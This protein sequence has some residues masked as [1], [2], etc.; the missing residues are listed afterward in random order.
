MR[1]AHQLAVSALALLGFSCADQAPSEGVANSRQAI[2]DGEASGAEQDGVVLLRAFTDDD[3]ELVC[4]GS[5]V[6]PNL[7]LTARHCVSYLNEA[8]FSCTVRGE[9][10]NNPDGGGR[11]GLH[12][13]AERIEVYGRKLPRKAPLARGARVISTLSPDICKNDIAFVVL[14]Q[15]VDLPL[16]PMRI[17]S[18]ARLHETGVLVGFGLD[19]TQTGIDYATQPRFQKRD[20]DIVALGPDSLAD[21]VT[22]VPPRAL[23]LKGPSGCIGDSGGP[24]LAQQSGAVLGVYSLQEGESCVASNVKHQMVHVP[25]FTTLIDEAFE[26]AG[27]LPTPEPEGA[28]GAGGAGAE[29]GAAGAAVEAA[30]GVEADNAAGTGGGSSS[31]VAGE[32]SGETPKGPASSSGCSLAGA[33]THSPSALHALAMLTAAIGLR[34]KR[35]RRRIADD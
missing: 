8:L 2:V 29:A 27:C 1:F 13:P 20:L 34:R 31:G 30:G 26:A 23:I 11:L 3:T 22:T 6:G 9:L 15:A 32:P 33:F 17:G 4:T 24:L 35:A 21:G 14:D 16:I 25:P 28:A 7:V 5:L 10:T 19:A 18:P 12:L